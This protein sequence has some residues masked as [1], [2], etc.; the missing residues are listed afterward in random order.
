M[1]KFTSSLLLLLFFFFANAEKGIIATQKYSDANTSAT[2]TVT[3]YVTESNC[4]MK[5]EFSDGKINSINW[6]IPDLA[7]RQLLT[8]TEGA[9]PT[10]VAKTYFAIPV[11]NIKAEKGAGEG[12]LRVEKTGE[13]KSL[14]GMNCEKILV[15]T[16]E[17]IT[18]MWVTKDFTA[19][20]FKFASF[21][22]SSFELAGLS[23]ERIP[24]FPLQS[25]TTDNG[26]KQINAYNLVSVTTTELS[27]ANFAIPSE[28]QSAAKGKN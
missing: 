24:G 12:R 13:S 28:Y 11:Q 25:T 21:F 7:N 6:F 27:P 19:G 14:S 3:W 9:V 2:I 20:F 17:N 22:Q 8:Y 1:M 26:G 16:K 23:E 15:T 4:K 18:E 5:M 10:G